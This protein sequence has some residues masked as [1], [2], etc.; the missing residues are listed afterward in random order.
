MSFGLICWEV[1]Y[2]WEIFGC[3]LGKFLLCG[4]IM[5]EL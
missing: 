5:S 3:K 1:M 2:I 4:K